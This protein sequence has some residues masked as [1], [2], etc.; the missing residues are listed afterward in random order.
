MRLMRYDSNI[1]DS[2]HWP[3]KLLAHN[4]VRILPSLSSH[5]SNLTYNCLILFLIEFVFPIKL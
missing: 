1:P 3:S 5:N 4:P 2:C